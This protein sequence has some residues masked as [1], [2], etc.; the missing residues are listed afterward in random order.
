M[1]KE[2]DKNSTEDLSFIEDAILRDNIESSIRYIY[3]LFSRS[4][5]ENDADF[6]TE[7]HRVIVLYVASV[8]EA[9]LLYVYRERGQPQEIVEYKHPTQ[10]SGEFFHKALPGKKVVVAVQVSRAAGEREMMLDKLITFFQEKKLMKK[11]FAEKIVAAKDIRN[12]F[13]LAKSREGIDCDVAAVE[14]A[15][16]LLVKT[17][18]YAPR[19]LKK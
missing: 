11:V 16:D 7:T 9:I 18:K 10:L 5:S 6:K 2:R 3:L 12:T 14:K 1:A 15:L 19:V 17:I 4:L 8:V 13:H